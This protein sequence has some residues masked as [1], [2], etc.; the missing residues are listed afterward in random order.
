MKRFFILLAGVVLLTGAPH[1]PGQMSAAV[2]AAK[3]VRDKVQGVTARVETDKESKVLV[4]V[5]REGETLFYAPPNMAEGVLATLPINVLRDIEFKI[6]YDELAVYQAA[7]QRNYLAAARPILQQVKP[8]LPFVDIIENNAAVPALEASRYLIQAARAFLADDKPESAET[9][10]KLYDAAREV[11]LRLADADWYSGTRIA[12]Y[13]AIQCL[14][15]QGK[16]ALAEDELEHAD[17]PGFEDDATGLYWL[18]WANL[19]FAQQ[20][21]RSALDAAVR[22]AVFDSKNITTFPDAL[23][24]QA[25]CHEEYLDFHRARD[26]YFEVAR[27]FINTEWGEEAYRRLDYVMASGLTKE[28]EDA[29][30]A[31]VF[32][33]RE[34]DMD[35]VV[36]DFLEKMKQ[37]DAAAEETEA[38]TE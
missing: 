26:V 31:K 36:T 20:E 13:L 8:L 25:K 28:G 6:E 11:L 17:D 5:K 3:P 19:H 22:S 29:N 16:F 35:V 27:L 9:A 23:L 33:D 18:T 38:G 24:I 4:L 34:E 21:I 1:A 2:R 15:D 7:R 10:S 14:I 30:I 37:R 32:F 12:E